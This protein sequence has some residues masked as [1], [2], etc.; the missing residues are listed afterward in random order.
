MMGA[1]LDRDP[2]GATRRVLQSLCD[3]VNEDGHRERLRFTSAVANGRDFYAFRFAENDSA[4]TLYFREVGERLIVVSEPFDKE[5]DWTEVPPNHALVALASRAVEIVPFDLA[6]SAAGPGGTGPSQK[7]YRPQVDTPLP[8]GPMTF[9]SDV[10]KLLRLGLSDDKQHL[11]IRSAGGRGES[12][13]V[14][15]RYRGGVFPGRSLDVGSAAKNSR[16]FFEAVNW[17]TGGQAM[18]EMLQAQLEVS[19]NV[20]VDLLGGLP[21]Q[22]NFWP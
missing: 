20:H 15:V 14:F 11:V 4:N 19:T 1:G 9:T 8:G 22:S 6:I 3:L 17:S 7:D 18:R 12:S 2:V 10:L 21:D 16:L 5:P 13:R